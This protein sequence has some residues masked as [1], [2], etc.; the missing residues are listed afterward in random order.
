MK[1]IRVHAALPESIRELVDHIGLEGALVLV[2]AYG[3]TVLRVPVGKRK[4]GKMYVSLV[5]LLG[6]QTADV[7]VRVY[8]AGIMVVPRCADALRMARNAEMIAKYDSGIPAPKLARQ[9]RLTDRQVRAI[10][11][12]VPETVEGLK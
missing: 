5:E 9:Y 11:K 7:L 10:L 8:G 3:G 4:D 12:T 6:E 2:K 1:N